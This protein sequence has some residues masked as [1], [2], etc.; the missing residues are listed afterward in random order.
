[1]GLRA[2]KE[3]P[4]DIIFDANRI[5][6][7]AVIKTAMNYVVVW[8]SDCIHAATSSPGNLSSPRTWIQLDYCIRDRSTPE[9]L[10]ITYDNSSGRIYLAVAAARILSL[11]VSADYG[12]SWGVISSIALPPKA[13]HILNFP[14]IAF[15]QIDSTIHVVWSEQK[16]R[17]EQFEMVGVFY[18]RSSNNGETWSTPFQLATGNYTH[19]NLVTDRGDV[20][21]VWNSGVGESKRLHRWSSD[22][23]FTWSPEDAAYSA[24]DFSDLAGKQG[25]P[26]ISEGPTDSIYVLVGT[27]NGVRLR[28]WQNGLWEAD[29]DGLDSEGV[30]ETWLTDLVKV[31]ETRICAY[32]SATQMPVFGFSITCKGPLPNP[33]E[34]VTREDDL[35]NNTGNDSGPLSDPGLTPNDNVPSLDVQN[36]YSVSQSSDSGSSDLDQSQRST[37]IWVVILL[38]AS[39]TFVL[40]IIVVIGRSLRVRRR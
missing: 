7:L 38:S 16:S 2:S 27:N 23:G 1:V 30:G 22:T 5:D 28:R 12:L 6:A 24:R 11:M 32:W 31:G 10:A 18:A 40:I 20:H 26:G 9:G 34:L 8:N 4:A 33:E 17:S 25:P 13:S 3:G 39:S 14:R 35:E 36:N 29:V 37:P 19:A 21:V 15:S